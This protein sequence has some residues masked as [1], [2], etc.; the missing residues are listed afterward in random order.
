M[1]IN[2][3]VNKVILMGHVGAD[4]EL[5]YTPSQVAVASFS[6]ATNERWTKNNKVKE[7]V[8]WHKVIAWGELAKHCNSYIKKGKK[9]YIEGRISYRTYQASNETKY[10]T[11]ILATSVNVIP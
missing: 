6:L 5:K 1:S 4:C 10:I 9:V 11:E 7:N 2:T 3:D 8:H